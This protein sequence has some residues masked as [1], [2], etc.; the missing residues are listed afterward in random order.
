M[1]AFLGRRLLSSSK[2]VKSPIIGVQ[3]SPLAQLKFCS[4]FQ[5][6]HQQRLVHGP[7]R[8]SGNNLGEPAIFTVEV[9]GPHEEVEHGHKQKLLDQLANLPRN[10]QSLLI[11]NDTPSNAEWSV[12]DDHFS[13]VTDLE[14][15]TGFNEELNDKAILSHWPIE[16]L[17]ISS[18]C[19]EV[20][21]SPFVLEGKVK[22]LV[23]LLTCG[24]RFEGPASQEL[25]DSHKEAIARGDAE[26]KYITVKKGTPEERKIE[27]LNVSELV[28]AWMKQKY[29]G[30]NSESDPPDPAQDQINLEI[31]E[32]LEND[33]IDTF[34]RMTLALPGLVEHIK[35][36]NIRSSSGLDFHYTVE[37]IFLEILP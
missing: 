34:S 22:H 18:A 11:K 28:F 31:L 13:S 7:L 9:E 30:P 21:R 19:G 32:I 6:S 3:R 15:N 25:I 26:A 33:A 16:R 12:I 2:C 35:T 8:D 14:M 24:L 5:H 20:F 27:I 36:L 17:L 10:A 29:T 37:E 1:L 23:L 4:E